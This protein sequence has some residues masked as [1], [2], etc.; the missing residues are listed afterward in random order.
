[1]QKR[2]NM[3][4]NI[5]S[6]KTSNTPNSKPA[7]GLTNLLRAL[8]QKIAKV[9]ARNKTNLPMRLEDQKAR[10]WSHRSE[11]VQAEV[12]GNTQSPKEV[13]LQFF[14]KTVG[15]PLEVASTFVLNMIPP[16]AL[17]GVSVDEKAKT[18]TIE[19]DATPIG[20]IDGVGSEGISMLNGGSFT[21]QKTVRG[22]YNEKERSFD[23]EE[24]DITAKGG[25][26]LGY[27]TVKILGLQI[28][29]VGSKKGAKV[30]EVLIK[31]SL[32]NLPSAALSRFPNT[33]G[34]KT[35]T[36]EKISS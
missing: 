36:W 9:G 13:L 17:K 11:K 12:P 10:K 8:A 22:K 35:L 20:K 24:G 32:L 15:I 4:N 5:G 25:W 2:N 14:L 27:Q 28:V 7:K 33:F 16:G 18:F 26:R 1:M 23:L 19:L 6:V 30:D 3:T 31:T 29:S 21:V 34:P